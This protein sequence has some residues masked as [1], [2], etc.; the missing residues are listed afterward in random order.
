M[1]IQEYLDFG[2]LDDGYK[3]A[4]VE[5]SALLRSNGQDSSTDFQV[6][7]ANSADRQFPDG[8]AVFDD[9]QLFKMER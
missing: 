5:V 1:T 7:W 4:Q 8:A 3:L 9:F 2:N 6:R